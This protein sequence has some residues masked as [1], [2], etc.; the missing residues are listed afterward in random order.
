VRSPSG[1]R[2]LAPAAQLTLGAA[3]GLVAALDQ[4][5]QELGVGEA[6]AILLALPGAAGPLARCLLDDVVAD[7]PRLARTAAGVA[8]AVWGAAPAA[9]PLRAARFCVVDLETTGVG[10]GARILEIGAV[11]MSGLRAVDTFERLVDPGV[12]LPPAIS[13]LTGIRPRDLRGAPRLRPVL[14]AFLRFAA[15]SVL[16]AHNA[17][18]DTGFLDRALLALG[19][20]RLAL[21][22]L[23]TLPLARRL[24]AGRLRR[25]DLATLADRFS[26]SVEPRHRALADA[27]ATAEV[28]VALLGLAQER[29]VA[30]V[31]QAIAFSAPPPRRARSRRHLARD[32]PRG[33]GVYVM[34]DAHGQALYVGKAS[35]LRTRTRSYFGARRQKP[36]LEA[37]LGV[38]ERIDTAPLG[39]ELEAALAELELIREWRPPANARSARPDRCAYLRLGLADPA[40]QLGV[41]ARPADDGALY[42]GPFRSRRVAEDAAAALRD[43]F[44]L[45]TCRPRLPHDDGGCL[46]GLLG[47][48]EAPCRGGERV[49]AYAAAVACARAYLE[50]RGGGAVEATAGRI[51]RLASAQRFE[52]AARQHRRGEALAA[53]DSSLRALR[54]ARARSGVLLA[55]DLE[56]PAVR[57]LT[58]RGGLL[59]DVRSLP[60]VG[61]PASVLA[62]PLAALAGEHAPDGSSTALVAAA[63]GPWLPAERHEAALLLST[64]L[65]GRVPGVVAV[66]APAGAARSDLVRRIAEG[67]ARV[68]QRVPLEQPGRPRR[69]RDLRRL[70]PAPVGVALSAI[71]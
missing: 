38:L 70:E 29:G 59:V 45:R 2:A 52:E 55:A 53:L 12:P 62:A 5:G 46:R 35:D 50:G 43:A 66:A 8:L 32:V 4:R 26:T 20:R 67:R 9:T 22:V 11:R 27:Q 23:D 49:G 44:G 68:P 57:C 60:R 15:G 40:P 1:R 6:A 54:R 65:A 42:A 63:P 34:R 58:V 28:L 24:L 64:A 13:S 14:D 71:A 17:G 7:D 47:R 41:R 3:D 19:G 36:Q 61:D 18:F 16:V 37:A 69:W 33:P 25:F 31:E 51:A 48:C 39:S 21:P 10:A 30:T 56:D